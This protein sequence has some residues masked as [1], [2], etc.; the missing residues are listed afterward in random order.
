MKKREYICY[1]NDYIE[2]IS[3]MEE[4]KSIGLT[5]DEV[6]EFIEN[7]DKLL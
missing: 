1:V 4:A 6:R 7:A 2:W 3:L 5:L